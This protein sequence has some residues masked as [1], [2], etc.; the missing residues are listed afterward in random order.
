MSAPTGCWPVHLARGSPFKR[1]RRPG[2]PARASY[3]HTEAVV[4][5]NNYVAAVRNGDASNFFGAVVSATPVTIA[6]PAPNSGSGG[7]GRAGPH[8]RPAGRDRHGAR[9][10]RDAERPRSRHLQTAGGAGARPVP[11]RPP[12]WSA[13]ANSLTLAAHD[14][15]RLHGH[16]EHLGSAI[17]ISTLPTA[18]PWPSRRPAASRVDD[19]RVHRGRR[20]GR[21]HHGPDAAAR[22]GHVRQR[23]GQRRC[24]RRH[25]RR[26][27]R[28]VA[29][30]A[31][32]LHRRARSWPPSRCRPTRPRSWSASQDGE[33]LILSHAA[34]LNALEP[35]VARR[36]AE[37]WTGAAGR[38]GRRL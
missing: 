8:R 10:G 1:H 37:G 22:A 16:R 36:K 11:T 23:R 14:R 13:G 9:R 29:A 7:G 26:S 21:R 18:T 15:N 17:L 34:F 6:V 4:G 38:P 3:P 5:R 19:R 31:L 27:G 2:P 25:R 24:L 30:C 20:P 28:R 12:A 32:R 35:L 33:L